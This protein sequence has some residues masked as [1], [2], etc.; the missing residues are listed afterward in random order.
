MNFLTAKWQN[1]I[2]ANYEVPPEVL[3]PFL[4]AGTELD[5]FQ[6][7][8]L[9]SL[10][11][12]LFS[13]IRIFGISAGF[14][15]TFE[16]INLRFY[17]LRRDGHRTKRGVVFIN[18]TVPYKA[19]AWLANKLYK[20]HYTAVP[21]KKEWVISPEE[22]KIDYFWKTGNHWNSMK[23]A[24]SARQSKIQ[25]GSIEEFIFEHYFGYTL[26]SPTVSQ[27]YM[28]AHSRWMI[29]KIEA[30]SVDCDFEAMYG[31]PFAFLSGLIPESIML[32]EGSAVS[33]KWERIRF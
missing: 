19:V 27:E 14:F 29:N 4:P 24:A 21:T 6:G 23:V 30:S 32:A 5:L 9:V 3:L 25:A 20:E 13:D 18:E 16:E 11:G 7:K 10:V 15:D 2:M 8:A 22:K 31:K 12:F 17:V 33:V 26:I 1:L 28:I